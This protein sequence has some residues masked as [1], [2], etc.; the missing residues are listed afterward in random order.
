[1]TNLFND[2]VQRSKAIKKLMATWKKNLDIRQKALMVP[3]LN[4]TKKTRKRQGFLI[5]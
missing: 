4:P 3:E 2:A 1:M 5:P